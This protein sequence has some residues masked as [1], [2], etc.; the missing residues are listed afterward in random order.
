MT[1]Q[2]VASVDVHFHSIQT[3][4]REVLPDAGSRVRRL[5]VFTIPMNES[6]VNVLHEKF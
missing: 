5:F 4:E 3:S 6:R 2:I 1:V